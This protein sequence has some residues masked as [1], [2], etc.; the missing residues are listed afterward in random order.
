MIFELV[1][2]FRDAL[3]A[4][5]REHPKRTVLTV[6]EKATRR[7]ALFIDQHPTTLFQSLWNLCV[8]NE[9]TLD[10]VARWRSRKEEVAPGFFWI[11]SLIPYIGPGGDALTTSL[12]SVGAKLTAVSICQDNSSL[13]CGG[14]DGTI[15]IRSLTS[16]K[17]LIR[18]VG[19]RGPVTAIASAP[20]GL[21]IVSSSTDKT[22]RF[23]DTVAGCQLACSEQYHC[24][25]SCL[26]FS[27][28]GSSVAFGTG[29]G[30]VGL[31][32]TAE[33]HLYFCVQVH[34]DPVVQVRFSSD[35]TCIFSHASPAS[36]AIVGRDGSILEGGAVFLKGGTSSLDGELVAFV[37]TRNID[38][39]PSHSP[40][41]SAIVVETLS[42]GRSHELDRTMDPDKTPVMLSLSPDGALLAVLRRDGSIVVYDTA[43]VAIAPNVHESFIGTM[44]F[45][46]DA[47]LL[48][49]GS[50]D[51]TI[52]LW[53]VQSG[54]C[55]CQL[56]QDG[57]R[58]GNIYFSKDGSQL[59]A[60]AF[61]GVETIFDVEELMKSA[62]G[63]EEYHTGVRVGIRDLPPRIR[64]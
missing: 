43:E 64:D 32:N 28:D 16:G 54:K 30:K 33:A 3:V 18:L 57:D 14:E 40:T 6:L 45:S 4:M 63:P 55:I 59:A 19:H 27:M 9:S 60:N 36:N 35:G 62:H 24:P 17:E 31:I 47:R 50:G 1:R 48:A 56:D 52:S 29:C 44:A 20:S 41:E 5:P 38:F 51:E 42:S 22:V 2:D 10:L 46:P 8:N 25:V 39:T 37:K 21:T 13:A 61:P 53:D 23:W 34:K 15:R 26:V 11:R 12:L 49:A 7:E 58:V